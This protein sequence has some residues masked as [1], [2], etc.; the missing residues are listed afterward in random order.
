MSDIRKIPNGI[1]LSAAVKKDSWLLCG[2]GFVV[3]PMVVFYMLSS[4]SYASISTP[5]S[6]IVFPFLLIATA[7]FSLFFY[8]GVCFLLHCA[9]KVE[10]T[11]D[12]VSLKVGKITLRKLPTNQ[13][14]TV[15]FMEQG[16]GRGEAVYI[17]QL[18]LTTE[19]AEDVL[20]NGEKRIAKS[21][22]IRQQL[23]LRK[24]TQSS[25]KAAGYAHFERYSPTLRQGRNP[26]ILLEYS[27]ERAC[28]LRT[29]LRSAEFLDDTFAAE[30][31]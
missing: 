17:P 1:A 23:R 25:K 14:L 22:T 31:I 4:G 8:H 11:A 15:G 30:N 7:V 26:Y 29:Y 16:F 27:M 13:I 19:S 18:V 5:E 3:L 28:V 9:A 6:Y 2:I 12:M 24:I 20:Q 10:I 21:R